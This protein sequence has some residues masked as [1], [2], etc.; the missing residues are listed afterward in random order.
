MISDDSRLYYILPN[1]VVQQYMDCFYTLTEI[2]FLQ[3]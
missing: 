3:Q 2:L 1:Y